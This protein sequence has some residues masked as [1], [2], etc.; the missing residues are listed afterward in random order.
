MKDSDVRTYTL[1]VPYYRQTH[2]AT[3]GPAALMMV[4]KYWDKSLNLTSEEE[5]KIWKKTRSVFLKGG[6]LHFGIAKT[7]VDLGFKSEIYQNIVSL[8]DK[9]TWKRFNFLYRNINFFWMKYKKIPVFIKEDI[10]TEIQNSLNKKI[11]PLV[12]INLEPITGENVFHWVVT[13]GMDKINVYVNDPN[14]VDSLDQRIKKDYPIR[15]DIFKKAVA[16]DRFNKIVF[17]ISMFRFS[18]GIVLVYK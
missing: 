12:F 7:A 9:R 15:I 6:T 13:T 14:M 11:P 1:N 16:S 2:P 17:P 4:M 18:P 3:C 10:L 5:F 8:N